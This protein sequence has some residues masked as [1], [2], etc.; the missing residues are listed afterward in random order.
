MKV[1]LVQEDNLILV[2][3]AAT[4]ALDW[5]VLL[6]A[7]ELRWSVKMAQKLGKEG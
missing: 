6:A 3:Q 5:K 4:R 2:S 7:G 1:V